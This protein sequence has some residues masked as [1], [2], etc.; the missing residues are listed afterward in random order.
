MRAHQR[1]RSFLSKGLRDKFDFILLV[2]FK[3]PN[4]QKTR[5]SRAFTV[6]V[7]V[8]RQRIRPFFAI[9]TFTRNNYFAPEC[10]LVRHYTYTSN[11]GSR[12]YKPFFCN[13]D[14]I[15]IATQ[16]ARRKN[17]SLKRNKS[18]ERGRMREEKKRF[19]PIGYILSFALASAIYS[20]FYSSPL[21]GKSQCTAP[22]H[23]DDDD[24]DRAAK[25][26]RIRSKNKAKTCL[27][28]I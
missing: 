8:T 22:L 20:E 12:V 18:A 7:R 23:H 25:F 4:H 14:G 28:G 26:A 13:S 1:P 5:R 19:I 10:S 24:D 2:N 16:Y 15:H 27:R 21:K 17:L 11:T 3:E 6:Y 9:H